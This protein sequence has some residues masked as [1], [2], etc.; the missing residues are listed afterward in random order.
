MKKH[1]NLIKLLFFISATLS[2]LCNNIFATDHLARRL[3]SIIKQS[4]AIVHGKV[5]EINLIIAQTV[6]QQKM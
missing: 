6:Q 4:T 1:K 2:F 3:S 5:I